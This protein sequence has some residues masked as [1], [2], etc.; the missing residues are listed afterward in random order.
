M[1]W[2]QIIIFIAM[3]LMRQINKNI[4][5]KLKAGQFYFDMSIYEILKH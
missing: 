4:S 2:K 5:T 3:L 1:Q